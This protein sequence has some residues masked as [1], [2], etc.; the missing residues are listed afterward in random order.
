M[1]SLAPIS[2]PRPNGY[3]PS[4]PRGKTRSRSGCASCPCL[5]ERFAPKSSVMTRPLRSDI[6]LYRR[7]LSEIRPYWPLLGSTFIVSLLSIPFVLLTPLPLKIA[8]DSV[9]GKKPVT[10]F[11]A[12]LLPPSVLETSGSLLVVVVALLLIISSLHQLQ[13]LCTSLL[14]T[15]TGERLL[16]GFRAQLSWAAVRLSVGSHAPD[17]RVAA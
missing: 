12:W 13:L 17:G 9:I 10:G 5:R 3:E 2:L 1:K 14:R 16:T 4:S 8:V 7:L 6:N 11:L 15:H